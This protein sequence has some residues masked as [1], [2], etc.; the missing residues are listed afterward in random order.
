MFL[1]FSCQS[2]EYGSLDLFLLNGKSFITGYFQQNG[3]EVL[4][5]GLN[6]TTQTNYSSLSY[7][8]SILAPINSKTECNGFGISGV[9]NSY[10]FFHNSFSPY[11]GVNDVTIG[12]V[13][14]GSQSYSNVRLTCAYSL[15]GALSYEILCQSSSLPNANKLSFIAGT[16]ADGFV[17]LLATYSESSNCLYV[18][19][20]RNTG[21]EPEI[22]LE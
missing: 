7:S 13:T 5:A 21:E 16:L 4:L 20:N 1:L 9:F 18:F 6:K 12:N 2:K 15:L 17:V 22:Y 3:Q 19:K 10:N 11:F 14:I 8:G